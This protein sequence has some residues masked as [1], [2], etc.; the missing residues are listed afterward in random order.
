MFDHL[1]ET[2]DWIIEILQRLDKTLMD[3]LCD[4]FIDD[5]IAELGLIR[6]MMIKGALGDPGMRQNIA[7][8]GRLK[9]MAMN[10]LVS[11]K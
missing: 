2:I 9:S 10:F 1:D 7:Q 5:G 11:G 4:D 3:S 8:A 6:K